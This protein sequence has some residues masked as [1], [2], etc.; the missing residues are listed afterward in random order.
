MDRDRVPA[1]SGK[2]IAIGRKLVVKLFSRTFRLVA[3]LVAAASAHPA[4]AQDWKADWDRVVAAANQEGTL[5][6]DSQPNIEMRKY[7]QDEWAKAYPKITLSTSATP[8]AQFIAQLRTERSVDKYLWDVS[9]SSVGS[10]FTFYRDGFLDPLQ[11]E[12]IFPDVKN[13][14][15]WGGWDHVFMDNAGKYVFGMS[16]A[17]KSPYYNTAKVPPDEIAKLGLKTLLDP[18]YKGKI[19][20][21]DPLLSGSGQTF[22]YVLRNRLGDDLL[23]QLIVDQKVVFMAQQDQVVEAMARGVGWIGIGPFVR[24]HLEP[25][26]QAGI[27]VDIHAFGNDPAMNEMGTGG[28]GLYVYNKRPHP[29][30]TRVFVNWILS[31]DIQLGLAKATLQ[32]SRRS[33][34]PSVSE[35]ERQPI[36]GAAYLETQREEHVKDLADAV[37]FVGSIRKSAQ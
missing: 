18:A 17:L 6:L 9:V 37:Q 20:W 10:G 28:A 26:L 8:P 12:F 1:G 21:H 3:L 33:D 23:R 25:Y 24:A 4:A 19:L 13:A 35:P 34:L 31:A 14:A 29:N 30:A 16:A 2:S 32:D 11:A 7:V 36:K 22:A 15:T 5:I 27:K